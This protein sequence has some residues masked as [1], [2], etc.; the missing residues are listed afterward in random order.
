MLKL[1]NT[2]G[3]QHLWLTS[4]VYY[5]N[6]Y[7]NQIIISQ[8][9]ATIMKKYLVEKKSRFYEIKYQQTYCQGNEEKRPPFACCPC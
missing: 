7:T 3:L 6:V 5:L 1:R 8:Q 2:G 4:S 9:V